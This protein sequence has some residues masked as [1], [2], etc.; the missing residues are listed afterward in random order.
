VKPL[1]V[2]VDVLITG[3]EGGAYNV[4]TESVFEGAS[5]PLFLAVTITL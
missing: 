2:I 5:P 3:A 4:V 1:L